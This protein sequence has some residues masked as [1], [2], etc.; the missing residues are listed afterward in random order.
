M[1][2]EEPH[3]NDRRYESERVFHNRQTDRWEVVEK[4]YRVTATSQTFYEGIISDGC[5]GK[6]ILEYGCGEGSSAFGLARRG[7][8]V[9]GID[10]SDGRIERARAAA[11]AA[12]LDDVSFRVMN[13]EA[14]DVPDASFDVICGTGIIHHLDLARAYG[15]IARTL[16]PSGKAVFLEPLGHNPLINAYRR[17]TPR[18]R[19]ADEHPLRVAD[20]ELAR[21]YFGRVE[22]HFFHLTSL[23]AVPLRKTRLFEPALRLLEAVD[24]GMFTAVPFLAR[25]AWTTVVV[26]A[27]PVPQGSSPVAAAAAVPADS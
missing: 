9:V 19:T 26:L 7:A 13:A 23:A 16:R 3:L 4:F 14:L 17:L 18:L 25:Y 11:E 10:I 8:S 24:Q 20:L 5:E 6:Q 22:S 2:A 27:D 21:R 15:E 12:G 1:S